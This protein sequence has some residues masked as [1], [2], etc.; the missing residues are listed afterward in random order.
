V[1]LRA[2]QPG[3]CRAASAAE[4][5]P[6]SPSRACSPTPHP[7][8]PAGSAHPPAAKP[9]TGAAKPTSPRTPASND[10]GDATATSKP[11]KRTR[12]WPTN[13]PTKSP[14]QAGGSV[15]NRWKGVN[16]R[17]A[18]T[19]PRVACS[20]ALVA[21]TSGC[22]KSDM[23]WY[24]VGRPYV[25]MSSDRCLEQARQNDHS[26]ALQGFPDRRRRHETAAQQAVLQQLGQPRRV[27][28]VGLA[29]R[30]D[31]HLRVHRQIVRA[32]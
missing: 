28:H 23:D 13:H 12:P 16:F 29:S 31:L 15:F 25:L 17:P 24:A 4:Q 1:T 20:L 6:S 9:P 26:G 10:Q 5:T 8:H 27:G 21:G 22:A 18:L 11:P 32:V 2:G 30:D 7:G 3:R 19:R 14:T